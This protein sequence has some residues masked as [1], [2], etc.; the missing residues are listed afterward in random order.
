MRSPQ[1]SLSSIPRLDSMKPLWD[2][3][4][5]SW[6]QTVAAEPRPCGFRERF[7]GRC[8]LSAL[9]VP[10]LPSFCTT[11]LSA[12][13]LAPWGGKQKQEGAACRGRNRIPERVCSCST[14]PSAAL[15]SPAPSGEQSRAPRQFVAWHHRKKRPGA[16][17]WF[18]FGLF[19]FPC[20][21]W[22]LQM[23]LAERC[24]CLLTLSMLPE[25]SFVNVA[26]VWKPFSSVMM[27]LCSV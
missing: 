24:S 23:Q 18:Q 11:S 17:E 19:A 3:L 15:G 14:Q 20:L 6:L 21:C 9:A 13:W 27:R 7:P 5:Y 8:E 10:P 26:G 4:P 2:F 12:R 1:S 22:T 25:S 16:E